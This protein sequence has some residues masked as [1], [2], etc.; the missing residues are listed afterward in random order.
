VG[1]GVLVRAAADADRAA[2]GYVLAEGF[3][4]K[5]G[6]IF[7]RSTQRTARILADLPAT[8]TV[9]VAERTG[10]IVGTLTLVL[11]PTPPPVLW[12]LLR[13]HLSVWESL[14]ALVFLTSLGS[15]SP[16]STTAVIEAVA[17]LPQARGQGV[18]RALVR[19][20][21]DAAR[22]AGRTRVALYVVD[23]NHAATRLYESL[24]FRV[25][26]RHRLLWQR[27]LFGAR[28]VLYMVAHLPP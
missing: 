12:P 11:E 1:D 10:Q 4:E 9:Y 24:G 15:S 25:M 3:P 13:Q 6:P 2:V 27:W 21:M 7:G 23:G 14:R 8:G 18:G 16:D 26:R 28:A 5:F 22:R 20:A 19:Y 17:V